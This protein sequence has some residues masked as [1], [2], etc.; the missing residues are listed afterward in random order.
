MFRGCKGIIEKP[1]NPDID[2]PA[3]EHGFV[4]WS[5]RLKFW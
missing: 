4:D 1:I 2:P 5:D 3:I